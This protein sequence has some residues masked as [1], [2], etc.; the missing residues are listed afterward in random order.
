MCDRV[1]VYVC[2]IVWE[3]MRVQSCGSVCECD[4]VGAEGEAGLDTES[5]SLAP[6]FPVTFLYH[7]PKDLV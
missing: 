5:V 4:R 6:L 7:I 2:A 1:G 3:C